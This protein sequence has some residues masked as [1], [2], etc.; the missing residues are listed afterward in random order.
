MRN[1]RRTIGFIL[2]IIAGMAAG[3]IYGWLIEP[4]DAANT[5]L[6]SLRGDYKADYVLMVAENYAVQGDAVNAIYQLKSIDPADP[7]FA[8]QDALATAQNLGYSNTE[9]QLMAELE[10]ALTRFNIEGGDL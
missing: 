10:K 8:V 3:L 6:A 7:L 1:P 2:A 5:S 4:A 9:L